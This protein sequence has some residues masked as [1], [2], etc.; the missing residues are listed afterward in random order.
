LKLGKLIGD[1]SCFG[2]EA[3]IGVR[4]TRKMK[5]AATAENY[6]ELPEK[7]AGHF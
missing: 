3:K 5:D 2:T 1:D 4:R 7:L 6:P